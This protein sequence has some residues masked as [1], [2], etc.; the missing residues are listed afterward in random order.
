MILECGRANRLPLVPAGEQDRRAAG[1]QAHAVGGHRALEELHRVVDR[2]R[3]RHRPARAVD[4]QVDVLRP[5]LVLQEQQLLDGEVG[6]VVGDDRLPPVSGRAAEEDDPVLQQQ[7]AERHLPLPGVV[8]VA[9]EQRLDRA[10]GA[11]RVESVGTCGPFRESW[12]ADRASAADR[13]H[14]STRVRCASRLSRESVSSLDCT[15]RGRLPALGGRPRSA[16]SRSASPGTACAS[17]VATS[18]VLLV[19]L[20]ARS[21]RT[22]RSPG[23]GRAPCARAARSARASIRSSFSSRARTLRGALAGL[24]GDPVDLGVDVVV[25]D[26]DLLRPRRSSGGRS[27]P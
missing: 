15:R 23:S 16:A 24:V 6:Q 10:G 20:R 4:V 9:L 25:L 18:P 21:P 12:P 7:V 8:A 13:D 11:D 26:L 19:R 17:T 1:R 5:V 3:R 27:A 14:G 22:R 2:Q